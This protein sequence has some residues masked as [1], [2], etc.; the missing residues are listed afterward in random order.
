MR[1]NVCEVSC[2]GQQFGDYFKVGDEFLPVISETR[3]FVQQFDG[4]KG[5][6]DVW[7]YM[8]LNGVMVW[9]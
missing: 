3:R 6:N 1:F 7:Y 8:G 9:V 2:M 4:S 5:L